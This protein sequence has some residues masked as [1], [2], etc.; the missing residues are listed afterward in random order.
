MKFFLYC[1]KVP[2][3]PRSVAV[4]PDSIAPSPVF[5]ILYKLNVFF[6]HFADVPFYLTVLFY[7][8][9]VFAV[10]PCHFHKCVA[11]SLSLLQTVILYYLNVILYHPDGVGSGQY[12]TTGSRLLLLP[13]TYFLLCFC[14]IGT[15]FSNQR[16]KPNV[17]GL[18]FSSA[19]AGARVPSLSR[20]CFTELSPTLIVVCLLPP[21]T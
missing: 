4:S 13:A 1:L 11:Q 12:W 18:A 5:T 9:K 20:G 10:L 14:T 2:I 16:R 3:S 21:G 15:A 6:M 19:H 17:P 8:L 7:H